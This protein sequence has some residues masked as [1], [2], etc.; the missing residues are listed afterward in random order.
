MANVCH[1]G[2]RVSSMASRRQS[3]LTSNPST[4]AA[5]FSSSYE[6]SA[7]PDTDIRPK[8]G[9]VCATHQASENMLRGNNYF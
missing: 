9:E 2:S 5:A 8:V 4:T 1:V 7:V 3:S 6:M